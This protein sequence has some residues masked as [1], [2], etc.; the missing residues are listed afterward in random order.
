MSIDVAKAMDVVARYYDL[1]LEGFDDDTALYEGFAERVE[2]DVLDLGC[3]TGRISAALSRAG[4]SVTAIDVSPEMLA[5]AA[6]HGTFET[7]RADLREL[8]LGRKFGLIIAPLGTLHHLAI[9]DRNA[10]VRAIRRHLAAGGLFVAD[11]AVEADWSAGGQPLVCQWTRRHPSSGHTVSKFVAIESDPT[12]LTQQ[13]TYFFDELEEDGTVKRALAAFDLSYFT[14]SE[15]TLLLEQNGM[16]I[17]G[18][19]GDYDLGPLAAE[20]ERMIVVARAA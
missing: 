6:R 19:Y 20:S 11:L 13:V 16:N 8:D 10:G 9:G 1:D 15:L 4:K 14:E 3:G 2:G 7:L 18:I 5:R 12:S 17:E